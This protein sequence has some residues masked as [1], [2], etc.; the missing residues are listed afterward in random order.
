MARIT[1]APSNVRDAGLVCIHAADDLQAQSVALRS[2]IM[3]PMPPAMTAR[4]TAAL[5]AVGGRLATVVATL[6]RAGAE[7]QIRADA[8]ELADAGSGPG[9]VGAGG[10]LQNAVITRPVLLTGGVQQVATITVRPGGVTAVGGPGGGIRVTVPELLPAA[11]GTTLSEPPDPHATVQEQ[12]TPGKDVQPNQPVGGSPAAAVQQAV[13]GP[14][15]GSDGGAP[16]GGGATPIG[17]GG[18]API[19]SG[20]T[21]TDG[22]QVDPSALDAGQHAAGETTKGLPVPADMPEDEDAGRQ[23]WAC[24]MA[25]SAAHD[26]LPPTLPVML[27][28]AGT[29]GRNMPADAERAGL[30]G[31]DPRRSYAPPGH[32]L[33]SDAQP[34]GQWWADH[35]AAQLDE[36]TSRL[37]GAAGGIRDVS[38]DDPGAL[39]RWATDALPGVNPDAL[40][41]AHEAA[42]ALVAGCKHEGAAATATRAGASGGDGALGVAQS[43]L[44]VREVGTNA[45]PKV[46]EYL[47][48]AGV[49]S[50]NPWCA[51]FVTWAVGQDGH[52]MQGQGWAAV[53]TWVNAAEN[54]QQGLQI[55]DAAHARPG[56]I[57]AYDWG[58]G[59][60]FG[61]DGHIGF[62]E[63]NV[64][65]G[66]NFTAVEGNAEDA[67]TRMQR[68]LGSAN[69]VFMRLAGA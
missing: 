53:S 64:D 15:G 28:L 21:I 38:L 18:G 57:V 16:A 50:G 1:I 56:D 12:A 19:D 29:G 36:I 35:P 40:A 22:D 48:S 61:S 11:D 3:P 5:G 8:A 4:Y 54:G 67:V 43:Q 7:L 32:G 45:G 25:G 14:V 58:H 62:L 9:A 63:S 47:R 66:G 69:V 46:D 24:W 68:N 6:E 37:R 52:H 2:L 27:S 51:S 55:V 10:Q 42:A 20:S 59:T 23:T 65:A 44:G 33:P 60:D 49:G 26:G 13:G 17:G 41:D 30:F 34:S 39:T 31:I